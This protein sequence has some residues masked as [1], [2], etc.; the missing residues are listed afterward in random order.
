MVTLLKCSL[1]F[2]KLF[3]KIMN[4]VILLVFC[5]LSLLTILLSLSMHPGMKADW[6]LWQRFEESSDYSHIVMKTQVCKI[7]ASLH[8]PVTWTGRKK[9]EIEGLCHCGPLCFC[10]GSRELGWD[11]SQELPKEKMMC[12]TLS[13]LREN[14]AVL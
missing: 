2:S 5:F 4:L 13:L 10:S 3:C 7:L 9:M 1:K 8:F 14:D 6:I 12:C 11:L